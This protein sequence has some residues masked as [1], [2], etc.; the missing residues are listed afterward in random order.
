MNLTTTKAAEALGVCYDTVREWCDRGII[1]HFKTPGGHRRIPT[2]SLSKLINSQMPHVQKDVQVH[3]QKHIQKDL[4]T[5]GEAAAYLD[6]GKSTIDYHSNRG[7][8][9]FDR[10]HRGWK[11]FKKQ[12]LDKFLIGK[13]SNPRG[14]RQDMSEEKPMGPLSWVG[15]MQG[16]HSHLSEQEWAEVQQRHQKEREEQ[17]QRVAE[18][19]ERKLREKAARKARNDEKSKQKIVMPIQS[20]AEFSRL[21]RERMDALREYTGKCREWND[22]F[23][24]HAN[25]NNWNSITQDVFLLKCFLTQTQLRWGSTR[26]EGLLETMLEEALEL[27]ASQE[28]A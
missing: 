3:V 9:P 14:L 26:L 10:D 18:S 12:D 16:L 15:E 2:G 4:F 1:E 21:S 11:V 19:R 25:T 24:E 17:D 28:L 20:R 23:Q 7:T 22:F 27:Q 13:D 8:L 5:T 6:L